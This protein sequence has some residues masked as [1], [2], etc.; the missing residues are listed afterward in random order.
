MGVTCGCGE[1]R[2]CARRLMQPEQAQLILRMLDGR[3]PINQAEVRLRKDVRERLEY[4]AARPAAA[5][6]AQHGG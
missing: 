5:E 2:A 6:E 1:C 3:I 4:I